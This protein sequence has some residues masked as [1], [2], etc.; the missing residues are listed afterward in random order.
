MASSSLELRIDW[1]DLD[2]FGHVNNVAFFRWLQASRVGMWEALGIDVTQQDPR[3]TGPILAATQCTFLQPLFYPGSVTIA[4]EVSFVKTTSF[5]IVHR[6]R[7]A[8]GALAAEGEDRVVMYHFGQGEK[9][10][11]PEALRAALAAG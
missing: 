3:G 9:A 11:I 10:E 8:A 4:A 5:G 6:I 1:A 2:L 7:N